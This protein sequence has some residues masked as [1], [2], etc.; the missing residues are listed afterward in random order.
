MRAAQ[1][2]FWKRCQ[3]SK[4]QVESSKPQVAWYFLASGKIG[5]NNHGSHSPIELLQQ[6]PKPSSQSSSSSNMSIDLNALFGFFLLFFLAADYFLNLP[7]E[8]RFPTIVRFQ[9]RSRI[10]KTAE[11]QLQSVALQR[12][13][14]SNR[15][16]ESAR[17]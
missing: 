7:Y 2:I 4:I 5:L 12:R 1:K 9:R 13:L 6:S 8:P 14:Y 17:L 10:M 3:K 11:C 16:G 15:A